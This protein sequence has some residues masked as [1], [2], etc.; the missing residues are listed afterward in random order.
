MKSSIFLAIVFGVS[1]FLSAATL[2]LEKTIPLAGVEG[3]IDHFAQDVAGGRLFI[4]ALGHNT[5]EVVDLQAGKVVRSITGL[6]EPQGVFYLAELNRLYVA[7]GGG[8]ALRV[9]DGTTFAPIAVIPFDDD[10]DNVR[11]DPAAGRLYIGHGSG[12]LGSVDPAT[13]RIV[14][15]IPLAAHPESFQLERNGPRVFVN[16]PSA[17]QVAVV[18]R[19]K[20]SVIATWSTGLA[21]A[22]FP[23]ALDEA[24][25]RLTIACRLPAR[26]LVFD[27]AT[28]REAAKLDLAG[29]CDDL[30]YD[31]VRRRLYASCGAGFIEVIQCRDDGSYEPAGRIATRDGA[32]T[33]FYSAEFDRLFLA[34]PKRAGHEAEIRVYQLQ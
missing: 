11:Y 34:L 24:N 20:K 8:G 21:A 7:N 12:A 29:D 5:V 18:D 15:E 17:H 9:Y 4:A 14:A 30:F 25:H 2:S 26:L 33:C 23:M 1:G 13:N 10:A 22:N 28:G 6:S 16:V 27:T 32:R 31:P 19:Q 3:R